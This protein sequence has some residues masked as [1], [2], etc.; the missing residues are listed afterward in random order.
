MFHHAPYGGNITARQEHEKMEEMGFRG[1]V[2][3]AEDWSLKYCHLSEIGPLVRRKSM[4]SLENG[5]ISRRHAFAC[6]TWACE[7]VKSSSCKP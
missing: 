1:L 5:P 4:E 6:S 2:V 7:A 3:A